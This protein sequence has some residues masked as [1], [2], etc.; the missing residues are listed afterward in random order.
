MSLVGSNQPDNGVLLPISERLREAY[1]MKRGSQ[2]VKCKPSLLDLPVQ[3]IS[4]VVNKSS[5]ISSSSISENK[6]SH[7]LT[8]LMALFR[9]IFVHHP[10]TKNIC[11]DLPEILKERFHWYYIHRTV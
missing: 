3:C 7:N 8:L 6:E 1:K 10:L 11:I 5:L 4:K 2:R 9:D